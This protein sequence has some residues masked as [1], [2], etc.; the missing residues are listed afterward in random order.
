[1]QIRAE[2]FAQ[3]C[4][5]K[6]TD[7]QT[8]NEENITSLTEVIRQSPRLLYDDEQNTGAMLCDSP[9]YGVVH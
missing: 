5:N 1:M 9:V 7:K 2:V 6:Q 8:N 3:S 4:Y